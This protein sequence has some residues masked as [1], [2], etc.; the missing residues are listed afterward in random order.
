MVA[1]VLVCGC[2]GVDGRSLEEGS[3]GAGAAGGSG[4]A[5]GSGGAGTGP[6]G[7]GGTG[8][9]TPSMDPPLFTDEPPEPPSEP[10]RCDKVDFLYV[11]DNSASMLDKQE[12]LA[13]SFEGFSRI[14]SETLGT[15]DHHIMVV[16]TDAMNS[17]DVFV[18]TPTDELDECT[19]TLGAGRRFGGE[20]EDCG[21]EGNQ[22]FLLDDQKNMAQAFSCLARVGIYGS[23]G[24]QPLGALLAAIG[25]TRGR[26]Q[27]C[28]QG[29]VRDDAVLVVTLITD[30]EDVVSS[31][32]PTF[33]NRQLVAVKGSEQSV[34]ML[35][36]IP[37]N[38]IEGG[39]PGGPCAPESGAEAPK[40]ERFVRSFELS[41]L[42]SVCAPDYSAFFADAVSSIDTACEEFVPLR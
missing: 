30:E 40:L 3:S 15:N 28:N 2:G 5:S 31:G 21:I 22:R 38:H 11:I 25:A 7:A 37:D 27:G 8:Q 42:G 10:G 19:W 29:F 24:E 26:A 20:G 9:V 6:V 4:G 41:A 35:G 13:R 34:V 18:A 33:W 1:L 32:D 39:L 16:D 36:L 12:N 23:A 17:G 14:V